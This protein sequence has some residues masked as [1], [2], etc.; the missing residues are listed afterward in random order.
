MAQT[1]I[2]D[3]LTME[4]WPWVKVIVHQWVLGSNCVKYYQDPTLHWEVMARTLLVYVHCDIDL[5]DMILY[6]GH[7]TPLGHGQYLWN[8][9]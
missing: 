9:I 8:I 7:D 5:E 3:S 1:Q 4:L 2:S 6:Q